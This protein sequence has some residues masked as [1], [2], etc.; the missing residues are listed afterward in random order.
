MKQTG[1]LSVGGRPKTLKLSYFDLIRFQSPA[2]EF[3]ILSDAWMVA[4]QTKR[5]HANSLTGEIDPI[6]GKFH[7]M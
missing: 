7:R 2:N 4:M 1:D 3:R 5:I 6:L